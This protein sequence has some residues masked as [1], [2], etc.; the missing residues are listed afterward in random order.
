MAILRKAHFQSW[1]LAVIWDFREH[2]TQKH[3]FDVQVVNVIHSVKSGIFLN[4]VFNS[5]NT[6]KMRMV[7]KMAPPWHSRLI[8]L[9]NSS[10]KKYVLS[11][12]SVRHCYRH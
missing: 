12:S 11:L 4:S 7:G 2:G 6:H 5:E 8:N 9:F 1:P 10:L 3:I